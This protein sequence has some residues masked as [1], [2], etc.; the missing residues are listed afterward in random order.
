MKAVI[1]SAGHGTRMYP[2]NKNTLKFLGKPLIQYHIDEFIKNKIDDFIVVCNKYDFK[3]IKDYLNNYTNI[4]YVIQQ[5]C[6]GTA[7]SINYTKRYL[8]KEDY[9]LVKYVDSLTLEDAIKPLLKRFDKEK[10]DATLSLRKATNGYGF[11]K[12]NGDL[13]VD[14]SEKNHN[15]NNGL[16]TMGLFILK[17]DKYF[18]SVRNENFLDEQFPVHYMLK[19]NSKINYN[20]FNGARIDIGRPNDIIEANKLLIRKFGARI[21]SSNV[22]E[23]AIIGKN[24]F[25][26]KEAI[27]EDGVI[28]KD[29]SYLN[30]RIC[31][32]T[33]VENSVIMKSK[34]CNNSFIKNSVVGNNCRIGKN[35]I[36]LTNN[37]SYGCFIGDN[38]YIDNN[39][40]SYP[41]KIVYGGLFIK[42]D[43]KQNIMKF[44]CILFDADNTLYSTKKVSKNSDLEALKVF[45]RY[46]KANL[47]MLYKDFLDIV[48]KVKFSKNPEFRHRLYSYTRLAKKYGV[49]EA[50]VNVAYNEFKNFVLN[51]IKVN[52]YVKSFLKHNKNVKKIIMS[53]DNK[54]MIELKLKKLY[55]DKYFDLIISSDDTNE[56][57]P[58]MKYFSFLKQSPKKCL[59]I[60]DNFDSDLI[61]AKKLGMKTYLYN[62][63]DKR[64][65]YCFN[66]FKELLRI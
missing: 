63:E 42:N 22:S 7:Q 1:L 40:S 31:K 64:A 33:K 19:K 10:L 38:V 66:S 28:I 2:F 55:L 14:I 62:S 37:N 24:C 21:E 51:N 15:I 3:I 8:T 13:V 56:M 16:A 50:V 11:V 25:I 46:S 9:F 41:N 26:G 47:D 17:S 65:D 49:S 27:I 52:P 18:D 59:V 6:N 57:K 44:D 23:N 34:I 32:N 4:K 35:F 61:I 48:K 30:G 43:I 29:F 54:E 36:T 53:E 58:S 5:L 12:L 39:I 60:G 20:V 45:Q